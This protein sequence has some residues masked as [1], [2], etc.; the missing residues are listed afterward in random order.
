MENRLAHLQMIQAIIARLAGNSFQ[1]R[2]WCITIVSAIFA[3]YAGK[4]VHEVIY[5]SFFSIIMFWI[6]DG[7]FLRQERMFRRLYDQ[8]R[9]QPDDFGVDFSM[10]TARVAGGVPSWVFTCF[11]TTLLAFYGTIFLIILVFAIIMLIH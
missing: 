11:S 2:G 4:S 9:L 1:L 7:Y 10:D 6:L 8:I 5:I 3:I